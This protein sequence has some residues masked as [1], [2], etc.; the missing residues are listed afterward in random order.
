MERGDD[1]QRR[2]VLSAPV[3]M[4][5]PVFCSSLMLPPPQPAFHLHHSA[6]AWFVGDT[7]L[8]FHS[9]DIGAAASLVLCPDTVVRLGSSHWRIHTNARNRMMTARLLM[10]SARLL[11]FLSCTVLFFSSPSWCTTPSL[12]VL[13]LQHE[14]KPHVQTN[15]STTEQRK[16]NTSSSALCTNLEY[17]SSKQ[18]ML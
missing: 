5:K 18:P 2:S 3:K 11:W 15:R 9:A 16:T 7:H 6:S 14:R 13:F 8:P 12:R 1:S 4:V 17:P 10:D